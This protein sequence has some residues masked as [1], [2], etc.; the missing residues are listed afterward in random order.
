MQTGL[1]HPDE[2]KDNCGFGLIAQI[3]G[4][5][6]HALLRSAIDALNCMTHRGGIAADGKTGDGCGLLMQ[7]PDRFLREVAGELFGRPLAELYSCGMVFL[8]QQESAALSARQALEQA[9]IGEGLVVT[10]WR[11]VPTDPTVLGP[12]ALGNMPR[13]EQIFVEAPA[14]LDERTFNVRLFIARRKAERAVAPVDQE[15]YITSLSSKVLCYKGLMMPADLPRF[16]PDL[17]DARMETAICTFHQRFSTNTLPKWP[18]AQPFRLLAHNGEINTI[19]GN[20][21]WVS[22]REARMS[23]PWLPDIAAI[24][25]LVN[26]EGSD[27]SSMDNMLETLLAGGVDLYRAVRMMIPPAWENVETIDTDLRAFHEYHSMLMEAWDGPAGIVLTEGSTA[28]CLLD[29]NGLRPAR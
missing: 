15:F 12:I 9:L 13:F 29:R 14:G 6:S 4:R 24:S 26:R 16:Y 2:F 17:H 8:S 3:E 27:S 5:T 21:N 28:V 22:A 1:Y 20:R 11:P 18:L 25:P 7:K 23:T 10:G 19:Q